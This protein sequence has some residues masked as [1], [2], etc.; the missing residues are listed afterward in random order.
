MEI[1]FLNDGKWTTNLELG[2]VFDS[3]FLMHTLND[4]LWLST[5]KI[6]IEF[7]SIRDSELRQ[8]QRQNAEKEN[9]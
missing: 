8:R 4:L 2:H 3:A 9:E 1:Y 6:I 5:M 7:F